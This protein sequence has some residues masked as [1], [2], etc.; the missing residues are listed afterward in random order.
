MDMEE[1]WGIEPEKK[2]LPVDVRFELLIKIIGNIF[3]FQIKNKYAKN[4]LKGQIYDAF[5]S[6]KKS[7]SLMWAAIAKYISSGVSSFNDR[8]CAYISKIDAFEYLEDIYKLQKSGEVP[9]PKLSLSPD[10]IDYIS[11]RRDLGKRVYDIEV[12][13]LYSNLRYHY[14]RN[15]IKYCI[16]IDL[17]PNISQYFP[18]GEYNI[19]ADICNTKYYILDELDER[20][21]KCLDFLRYANFAV[22]DNRHKET[23]LEM[24]EMIETAI[25]ST[26]DLQMDVESFSKVIRESKVVQDF[27]N[28]IQYKD[29]E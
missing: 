5:I 6:N 28:I 20:L 16:Y 13:Y 21:S 22:K 11:Q 19:I 2:V 25:C 7:S 10:M 24:S 29:V 18:N 12:D 17:I 1:Y 4:F 26:K 8:E 27:E 3:Y 9:F 23:S 14:I 15:N